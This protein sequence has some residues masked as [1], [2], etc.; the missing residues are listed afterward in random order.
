[1]E[2]QPE[3]LQIICGEHS[4]I[5]EPDFFSPEQE[6]VLT[7]EKITNHPKFSLEE[8]RGPI[9]GYDIAV[10]HVDDTN[11]RLKEESIWP[12]CLP[13]AGQNYQKFVYAGWADPEPLYRRRNNNETIGQ[14]KFNNYY[15]NQ[16]RLVKSGCKDPDWMVGSNTYYPPGT[17][18]YRDPSTASCFEFGTSGSGIVGRFHEAGTRQRFSYLGPLSMYKGCD[19]MLT[20]NNIIYYGAENPGIFTDVE[21]YLDWIAEQYNLRPPEGYTKKAS[22]ST[23]SGERYH[24]PVSDN[25]LTSFGTKCDFSFVENDEEGIP[26]KFDQCRLYSGEGFAYIINRCRDEKG[27]YAACANN[28]VGVNPNAIVIGGT[29]VVAGAGVGALGYLTLGGGAAAAAG[30]GSLGLMAAC[31]RPLFCQV[32][33]QFFHFGLS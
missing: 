27:L 1:M 19:R 14:Y 32:P 15:P 22:C 26:V 30:V 10:Y 4:I 12:A 6:I 2:A 21:C 23:G 16:I 25:C 5:T 29:A 20:I 7:I 3:D 9:E 11:L 18:C 31:P 28:C 24:T 33:T 17:A 8:G 13:R